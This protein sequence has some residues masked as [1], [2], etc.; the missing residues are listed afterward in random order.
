MPIN[1]HFNFIPNSRKP[2]RRTL[3]DVSDGDTPVIRQPIRAVSVDTAEKA[4]YAGGP[5]L[6]QSKL[7]TC[8][9]RLENGFFAAIPAPM[10]AYLI[11]KISSD[12][13]KRHIE[14][15]QRAKEEF[16]R[17]LEERLTR[18][19]GGRRPLGVIPT[20]EMI[21]TFGRLLAYYVP[22]YENTDADP[23][24]PKD[25]QERRTFNFSMIAN[26]WGAFFPIYPSLPADDDFNLAIAAAEAAWTGQR[27]QWREFGRDLLLGYE[28]RLCIKLAGDKP[29]PALIAEAFQRI[30]VDLRTRDVR[31]EFGFYDVP[32]YARM[33]IWKKDRDE[34]LAKLGLAA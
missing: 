3:I 29:A 33:W 22:W 5:D 28:Y 9:A 30:C 12:A 10:R 19:N 26:G 4:N 23:L 14:A 21:D 6:A 11:G 34:A 13:A 24:P 2:A 31:D 7:E 15:A 32:P 18:P 27:G 16:G 1:V 20:G 8:R 17:L 25:A